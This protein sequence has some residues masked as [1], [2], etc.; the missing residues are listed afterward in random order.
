MHKIY[1]PNLN[2]LRFIAAIVVLV[3]HVEQFRASLKMP[4]VLTTEISHELGGGAVTFFFS[5]T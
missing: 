5:S 3:S 1:F 4:H 2:G